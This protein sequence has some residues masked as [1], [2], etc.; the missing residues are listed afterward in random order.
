MKR[1]WVLLPIMLLLLA[2]MGA[3]LT[4]AAT[5]TGEPA[6][7]APLA[8]NEEELPSIAISLDGVELEGFA[9]VRPLAVRLPLVEATCSPDGICTGDLQ[10][11]IDDLDAAAGSLTDKA[12]H[13]TAKN[14]IG[15]I[16][17]LAAELNGV[18]EVPEADPEGSMERLYAPGQPTYGNITLERAL[19][20]DTSLHGWFNETS[21]GQNIRKSISIIM[22]DRNRNETARYNLFECWPVQWR[23]SSRDGHLVE[24]ITFVAERLERAAGSA[25]GGGGRPSAVTALLEADGKPLGSFELGGPVGGRIRW[26]DGDCDDTD[27]CTVDG[28][29]D[30]CDGVMECAPDRP[31]T[32][33]DGACVAPVLA[34]LDALEEQV[35]GIGDR[36]KHDIA[37]NAIR[38]MKARM[39]EVESNLEGARR[40][41]RTKYANIVLKRGLSGDARA[42]QWMSFAA[43]GEPWKRNL[44]MRLLGQDGKEITRFDMGGGPVLY[45]LAPGEDGLIETLEVRVDR[46]EMK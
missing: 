22:R 18:L 26:G 12:R 6:A 14:A 7:R 15:N 11:A 9:L 2:S 33:G 13:D 1:A 38:N 37:M 8:V 43:A 28:V 10:L 35:A 3:S 17:A 45:S 36:A 19:T 24:E 42:A 25:D 34:A 40:P 30:D 20:G 23:V 5:G 27:S 39:A 29:D 44:T 16:R 41:G 32:C 21:K 46:I 4:Q 31:V